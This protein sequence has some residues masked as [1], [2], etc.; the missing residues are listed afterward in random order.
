MIED[1]QVS[2]LNVGRNRLAEQTGNH[3][4]NEPCAPLPA[5]FT[6]VHETY[7]RLRSLRHDQPSGGDAPE[8]HLHRGR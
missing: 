3:R 7:P 4:K 6:L 2:A 8:R 1:I 5:L